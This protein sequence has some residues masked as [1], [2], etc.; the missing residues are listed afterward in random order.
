M[1][2]RVIV[3]PYNEPPFDIDAVAI[4]DDT[5]GVVG[6]N[7]EFHAPS[8]TIAEAAASVDDVEPHPLGTVVVKAGRP[9]VFRAIV[10]D[11]SRTPTCT[12]ADV[13]SALAAVFDE[14]ERRR[15]K[16][17]A[18]AAVGTRYRAVDRAR[19]MELFEGVLGE[20]ALRSVERIWVVVPDG[21][22]SPPPAE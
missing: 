6:A 19:F 1:I 4:E 10:H 8:M 22:G 7:P 5:F 11:M 17:I 20:A 3:G 14:A 9:L 16:S 18:L 21:F 15:L 13:R 12:E 2:V